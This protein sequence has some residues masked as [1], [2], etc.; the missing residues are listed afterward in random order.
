MAGL[1]PGHDRAQDRFAVISDVSYPTDS[2]EKSASPLPSPGRAQSSPQTKGD[3]QAKPAVLPESS[4]ARS[5]EPDKHDRNESRPKDP[6]ARGVEK[7]FEANAQ[8][9]K[10]SPRELVASLGLSSHWRVMAEAAREAFDAGELEEWDRRPST[11]D[12]SSGIAANRLMT[13]LNMVADTPEAGSTNEDIVHFKT[14]FANGLLSIANSRPWAPDVGLS[15]EARGQQMNGN[16]IAMGLALAA[17][18]EPAARFLSRYTGWTEA[19]VL[20]D[21]KDY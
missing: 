1:D 9:V 7:L 12:P 21:L 15:P 17:G 2:N 20:E 8:F 16:R 6:A 10:D 5:E 14:G 19:Q 18:R 13:G 11:Q 4:I 3:A